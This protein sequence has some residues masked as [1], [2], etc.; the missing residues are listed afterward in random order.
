VND[1]V[2]DGADGTE[3]NPANGTGALGLRADDAAAFFVVLGGVA[4][5][6]RPTLAL[7]AHAGFM[8]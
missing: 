8:T 6:E 2:Y 3:R 7:R 5:G 1:T 4:A